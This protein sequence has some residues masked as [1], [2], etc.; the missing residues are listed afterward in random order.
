MVESVSWQFVKHVHLLAEAR[1]SESNLSL[2][3]IRWH[4]IG[5]EKQGCCAKPRLE[6]VIGSKTSVYGLKPLRCLEN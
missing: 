5:N 1:H 3:M 4:K 2:L 6:F